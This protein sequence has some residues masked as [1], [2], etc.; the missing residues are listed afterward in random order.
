MFGADV[1]SG[2]TTGEPA[3]AQSPAHD[4]QDDDTPAGDSVMPE[5]DSVHSDAPVITC[6]PGPRSSQQGDVV[7]ASVT[8]IRPA[9]QP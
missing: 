6:R 7:L 2:R 5:G 3:P 1:A 9:Q 4:E 8:A